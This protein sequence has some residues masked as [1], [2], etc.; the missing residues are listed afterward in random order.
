MDAGAARCCCDS[1]RALERAREPDR[2]I[3]AYRAAVREDP[4]LYPAWNDLGVGLAGDDRLEEAADAFRHAV[5]ARPEYGLAWFNL[6]VALERLGPEHAAASQGAF[7]R[8]VRADPDL[9][10]RERTFVTDSD[11]YFTTLDL[12]KPLPPKWEFAQTQERAPVAAAGLAVALLLGLQLSRTL[13]GQSRR[14]EAQQWLELTRDALG[15][16]PRAL[17]SP[18]WVVAIAATVIVFLVPL[19]RSP[20]AT[21][22][23]AILLVLGV[24]ILIVIVLRSRLLIALREGVALRQR[25]WTPGILAGLVLALFG[26]AWAPLPVAE[27][28]RPA[29]AVHWIGPVAAGAAA[30]C[31]LPLG[32]AFEVPNTMA[33]GSAALVMAASLLTPIE[34]M[35]GGLVA[36][37]PVG[38]AAVVAVLGAALFLLLGLS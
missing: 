21:W 34:P 17:A 16:L 24:G 20:E 31:L 38:V 28:N 30:L 36:K 9:R 27:T 33:L 3:D 1:I 25:G 19:L 2:A 14:K 5:G 11:P 12:S 15:R 4:S 13:V 10:G 8:A 32:V 35:D 23:S 7:G 37:G 26:L 6:G 22:T 18:A 29:P